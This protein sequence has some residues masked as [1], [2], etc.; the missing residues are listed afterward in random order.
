M[1]R[2]WL[3]SYTLVVYVCVW[4]CQLFRT[5][6]YYSLEIMP[7][8]SQTEADEK[9]PTWLRC[10]LSWSW[11]V[12]LF[13]TLILFL[14]SSTRRSQMSRAQTKL[15]RKMMLSK[16]TSG[17]DDVC[18]FTAISCPIFYIDLKR[19]CC[20]SCPVRF[21]MCSFSH[22]MMIVCTCRFKL[23]C[24]YQCTCRLKPT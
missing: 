18:S 24:L 15:P 10:Q 1:F 20:W 21:T 13:F 17:G 12:C 9:P 16:L 8:K 5:W 22:D 19:F 3:V 11:I 23:A 2:N 6:C 4:N 7:Q 14:Y